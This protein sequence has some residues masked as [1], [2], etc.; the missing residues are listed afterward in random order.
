M[1]IHESAFIAPGAI[2]LGDVILEK[3]TSV[4]YHAT[5]RGDRT[6]IFIGAGSNIQDNCVIHGDAGYPVSIGN[7]VSVGHGA[8][9]HGCT[10][11]ENT[12]IG[13][14]AILLNGCHIGRN[15]IIAAG[16][17]VTGGTVIPDNSLV[18]GN[19]G[20]VKRQVKPEEI[21]ANRKNAASYAEEARISFRK[22]SR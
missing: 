17:L 16:A 9:L 21:M 14:G 2:V 13:M 19:P 1:K 18:I 3:D 11:E 12:L 8:I 22:D 20:K 10:V 6:S 5:I 4:W 15:C 7:G